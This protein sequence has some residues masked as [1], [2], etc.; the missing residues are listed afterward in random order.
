M[1]QAKYI[2]IAEAFQR[3]ICNGDYTFSTI[4]GAQRLADE[5]GVSYLTA[6]QAVQKLIDDGVLRRQSGG[7]LEICAPQNLIHE[8]LKIALIIPGV[9]DGIWPMAIR[10]AAQRYGCMLRTV[11]YSHDDDP[12]IFEALNGDFDLIFIMSV[13][14]DAMLINKLLQHKDKGVTWFHDFTSLGLRCVDGPS[15][16]AIGKLLNYL[17]SLGHDKIDMFNTQPMNRTITVRIKEWQKFRDKPGNYGR[18]HNFPVESFKNP[19]LKAYSVALESL[20]SRDFDATALF[21]SSVDT[22]TGLLRACYEKG[23]RVGKDLSVCS[24]GEP[25][26]AGMLIPSLTVVNRPPPDPEIDAII[27]QFMH[28]S[29]D[30]DRLM[31]RPESEELLLGE[32]TAPP[33]QVSKQ[34]KHELVSV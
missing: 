6:R 18:L 7:R 24:F 11:S 15:P 34:L 26:R 21:C 32:S 22:A 17:K 23:V 19:V 29:D 13:R 31:F 28:I 20:D 2:Q 8:K 4:P 25:D 33:G 10:M 16:V 3:R 12:V 1:R 9:F 27:E 14:D 5:M 30:P